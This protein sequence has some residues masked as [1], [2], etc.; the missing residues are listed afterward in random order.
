MKC[1][2]NDNRLVS[3]KSSSMGAYSD[4]LWEKTEIN[5]ISLE[6]GQCFTLISIARFK[7]FNVK[8]KL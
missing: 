3:L 5:K 1:D 6:N 7:L 4:I 8:N 2:S